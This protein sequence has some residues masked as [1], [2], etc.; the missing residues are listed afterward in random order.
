MTTKRELI[1]NIEGRR[2]DLA[3]A[4]KELA[5]Y[6]EPTIAV[7]TLCKVWDCNDRKYLKYYSHYENGEHF[8][9]SN[10]ATSKTAAN[11]PACAWHNFKII[12][13]PGLPWKEI[14]DNVPN[15]ILYLIKNR[16]G[17]Y[18]LTDYLS[19][20]RGQYIILKE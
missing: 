16:E 15:A 12:E 10:G 18:L 8:F 17:N 3:W 13:E 14:D 4:E 1:K 11:Y 5:E 2:K 9:F 7:D 6:Q 20:Y 19:D